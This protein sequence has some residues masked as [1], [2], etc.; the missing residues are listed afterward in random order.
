D[1]DGVSRARLY[2][3]GGRPD[4]RL[5]GGDQEHLALRSRR[6][7]GHRP[8]RHPRERD[9]RGVHAVRRVE[10]ELRAL[11]IAAQGDGTGERP[12]LHA[13]ELGGELQEEVLSGHRQTLA[14]SLYFFF[15]DPWRAL[16]F[17]FVLL[18]T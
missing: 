5:P 11:R 12:V 2:R 13:A 9:V 17:G 7:N 16:N 4:V 15:D 10:H 8:V 6:R 14:R 1:D 18:M 3:A